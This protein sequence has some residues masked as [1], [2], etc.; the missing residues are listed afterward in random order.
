PAG[1]FNV[2]IPVAD[3]VFVDPS[4]RWVRARRGGETAIDSRRAKVLHRHGRLPRYFVPR[5]DVHWDLLAGAQP[6]EPPPDAPGLDG[7]VAFAWEDLDA[8]FE[9]DEQLI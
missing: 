2:D 7:Y 4:P 5:D 1:R 6:Q 3:L 9:E 8:W